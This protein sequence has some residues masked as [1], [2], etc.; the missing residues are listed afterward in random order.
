MTLF[1]SWLQPVLLQGLKIHEELAVQVKSQSRE[2]VR[3]VSIN[4]TTED[5]RAMISKMIGLQEHQ[6]YEQ[7]SAAIHSRI[8]ESDLMNGA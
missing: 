3:Q 4:T 8:C 5:L 6:A 7:F 1:T 2:L